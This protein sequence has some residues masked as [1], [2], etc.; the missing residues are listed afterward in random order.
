V[1]LSLKRLRTLR[2][3][4]AS[5]PHRPPFI[6]AASGLVLVGKW[7]YVIADDELH[8]GVFPVN[9]S[10][11]GT[12]VRLLP[13]KLPK[14]PKK[15]KARKADF[16][17]LTLLPRFTG[18]PHGAL[19]ALGSGSR[20]NRRRGVLLPLDRAG[21]LH[22]VPRV[23]DLS[24]LYRGLEEKLGELN[25]E[26]AVVLGKTLC[27]LNRGP[28]REGGS[29]LVWLNLQAVLRSI[30]VAGAIDALPCKVR[31]YDLGKA[32]GVPL[33]FTDGV[34]SPGGGIVFT[35]VAESADDSYADGA[36]VAAALGVIRSDGELSWVR[37]LRPTRKVEGI[38]VRP[39]SRGR[40]VLLVT[41]A[42]DAL[43]PAGLYAARVGGGTATARS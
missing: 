12:L 23:I 20:P 2:L 14:A 31:R 3:K 13:G 40:E 8:L 25:V 43:L 27:L 38:A 39:G 41:D 17:V 22:G 36:C 1:K 15:R 4:D 10:A 35:A 34:A 7:L 37:K 32:K 42:D 28:P 11:T 16:E 6:S 9:G 24:G 30:A 21:A 19:L 5:G 26:G 18:C 33:G 29:A